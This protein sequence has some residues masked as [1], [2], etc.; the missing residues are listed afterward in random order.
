[1]QELSATVATLSSAA[2][3]LKEVSNN[4]MQQVEF[5]KED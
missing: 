3:D 5:F 4:L 2:D 1:M